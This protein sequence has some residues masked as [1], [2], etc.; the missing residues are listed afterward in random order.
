MDRISPE[1]PVPVLEKEKEE[2]FIGG[3]GL[4]GS[5]L[6][7]IGLDTAFFSVVGNDEESKIAYQMAKA[8]GMRSNV[9]QEEGRKTTVKTRYVATS[10]Y[11]QMIVRV[12]NESRHNL[13]RK[14]ENKIISAFRQEV[15]GSDIVVVSDYNKGFMTHSMVR[16]IVRIS[17]EAGVPVAVDTKQDYRIYKGADYLFPNYKE[18]CLMYSLKASNQDSLIRKL[19]KRLS[20][21]MDGKVIVKRSE[22]GCTFF[23][24]NE[25]TSYLPSTTEVVNVSGAGDIFVAI[26]S[27]MVSKG[28]SMEK[29]L[30]LANIGSGIA[31]SKKHP[32]LTREDFKAVMRK[33]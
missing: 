6:S 5:T 14:T 18:I 22:K 8:S 1:A 26:A 25:V 19:G 33:F 21:E 9:V 30:R 13:S 27:G 20:E 16:S 11:F 23:D 10:P 4:V 17:K 24:R 7:A 3:A 32:S 28:Y 29:A 2:R 12:D 15:E 31:I